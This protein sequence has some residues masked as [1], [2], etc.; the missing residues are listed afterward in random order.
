MSSA[1]ENVLIYSVVN[2]SETN[3]YLQNIADGQRKLL[4]AHK[5]SARFFGGYAS[6]RCRP[7]LSI[8]GKTVYLV[9]NFGRQNLAFGKLGVDDVSSNCNINYLCR[10]DDAEVSGFLLNKDCTVALIAWH[11]ANE[12]SL[13][14]FDLRTNKLIS[15][16]KLPMPVLA[17]MDISPDGTQVAADVAAFIGPADIWIGA[18]ESSTW[19]RLTS[20]QHGWFQISNE[21]SE[22]N[23]VIRQ[24]DGSF[25]KARLYKAK[26]D[27]KPSSCVF[28]YGSDSGWGEYQVLNQNGIS[29][30]VP[31]DEQ[32]A[33]LGQMEDRT[34]IMQSRLKNVP[35]Y[36]KYL[37]EHSIA[38]PSS[39]GIM[40]AGDKGFLALAAICQY[41]DLFRACAENSGWA[42]Y[43]V[44]RKLA[45]PA[46]SN[47][48][49]FLTPVKHFDRVKADVMVVHRTIKTTPLPC[50]EQIVAELKKSHK[51][52]ESFFYGGKHRTEGTP[53]AAVASSVGAAAAEPGQTES[54]EQNKQSEGEK[55]S[56]KMGDQSEANDEN[57]P[58]DENYLGKTKT[59]FD[60]KQELKA[61]AL[62]LQFLITQLK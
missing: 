5:P 33:V 20:H 18:P 1:K 13:S 58:N 46:E 14:L 32:D 43:S 26:H 59:D 42:D 10:R 23:L 49:D 38:V 36:I 11:T 3:L 15:L 28:D 29:V 24:D 4:T 52:V 37:S 16:P 34:K 51:H 8:D 25:L 22:E 53:S 47:F 57:K 19:R 17:D 12:D 41:P 56:H 40:G 39:F 2:N 27:G 60:P 7:R 31:E 50:G 45:E 35:I 6:A 9:S 62:M 48:L 30:L 61:K 54:R 55:A 21:F 44:L